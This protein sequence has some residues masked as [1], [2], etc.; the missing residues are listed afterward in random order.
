MLDT[1]GRRQLDAQLEEC[2]Q[3][4]IADALGVGQSAV[5]HWVRGNSRPEAHHR[6]ALF[7]LLGIPTRAWMT[8]EEAA[9]VRRVRALVKQRERERAAAAA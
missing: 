9:M 3:V 7:L 6:T 8:S 4:Q 5:S 1:K 2:T